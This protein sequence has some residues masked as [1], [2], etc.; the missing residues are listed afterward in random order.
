MTTATD[1]HQRRAQT[2]TS[3]EQE[4]TTTDETPTD[5]E[6]D[7]EDVTK[8]TEETHDTVTPEIPLSAAHAVMAEELTDADVVDVD[9]LVG[10]AVR[11]VAEQAIHN[12]YQ[13]RRYNTQRGG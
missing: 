11:Q 7:D 12:E 8:E 1:Y 9:V 5:E 3:N 13:Q 4:S 2:E 6:T 10:R